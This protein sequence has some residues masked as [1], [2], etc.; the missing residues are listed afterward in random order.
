ME[1]GLE[2]L[3]NKCTAWK[4]GKYGFFSSPYFPAFGLNTERQEYLSVFT[5]N[6]GKCR[7]EETSYLETFQAGVMTYDA[8]NSAYF[9]KLL[10][11]IP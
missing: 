7:P 4:V 6:A 3:E 11:D 8:E 2:T 5:P 9:T 1:L 10:K